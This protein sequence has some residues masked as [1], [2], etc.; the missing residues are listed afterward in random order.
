MQGD[1]D[2]PGD[3]LVERK[4][5]NRL[6]FLLFFSVLAFLVTLGILLAEKYI[7]NDDESDQ[8]PDSGGDAGSDAP[9]SRESPASVKFWQAVIFVQLLFFGLILLLRTGR[10]SRLRNLLF[11]L[12]FLGFMVASDLQLLSI[13]NA[14]MN[15]IGRSMNTPVIAMPSMSSSRNWKRPSPGTTTWHRNNKKSTARFSR[16]SGKNCFSAV[17]LLKAGY[18]D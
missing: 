2:Q 5:R 9:Q 10:R 1:Y 3:T 6:Q 18:L 16:P 7:I 17:G 15:W 12:A 13:P 8:R 14:I 4:K 11:L